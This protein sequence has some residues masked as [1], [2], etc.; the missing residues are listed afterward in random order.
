MGRGIAKLEVEDLCKSYKIDA[1]QLPVLNNINLE[2]QENE[3][4]VVLGPGLCGK[5][6]LLNVMAGLEPAD[7][8]RILLDGEPL[9]GGNRRFRPRKGDQYQEGRAHPDTDAE[10][11]C[12][13]DPPEEKH[14]PTSN[15]PRI[16]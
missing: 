8:G 11:Y 4:L 1:G 13:S 10:E 6:S 14:E 12:V 7:S 3:F 5:T 16:P 15:S 9:H 2:V